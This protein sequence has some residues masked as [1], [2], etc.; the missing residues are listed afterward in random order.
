VNQFYRRE[1]A[2]YQY[3]TRNLVSAASASKAAQNTASAFNPGQQRQL[4]LL[5][6]CVNDSARGL[7]GTLYFLRETSN[8]DVLSQ[9]LEVDKNVMDFIEGRT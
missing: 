9:L 1:P 2:R 3:A 5:E 7:S 8:H 4:T 6:S